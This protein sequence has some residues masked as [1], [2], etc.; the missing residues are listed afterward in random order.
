MGGQVY[1]LHSGIA[2]IFCIYFYFKLAS[3]GQLLAC[4]SGM[5]LAPPFPDMGIQQSNV[6][7]EEAWRTQLWF[8]SGGGWRE[9]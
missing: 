9:K 7:A 6:G 5:Y 3:P 8:L 1:I 4:E 2:T